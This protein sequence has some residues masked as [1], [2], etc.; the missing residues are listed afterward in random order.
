MNFLECS[1]DFFNLLQARLQVTC[2]TGIDSYKKGKEQEGG[3]IQ[4][5]DIFNC[6]TIMIIGLPYWI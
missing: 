2:V 1:F 3:H 5:H 6:S 4:F